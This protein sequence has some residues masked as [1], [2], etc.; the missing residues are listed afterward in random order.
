MDIEEVSSTDLVQL[1]E[2]A[3][4]AVIQSVDAPEEL[5]QEI[6]TDT[7]HHLET[8]LNSQS[9]VFLKKDSEDIKGFILI[10]DYWNLSDLFVIPK[11]HGTGIGKELFLVALEKCQIHTNKNYIRVNSSLNAQAFY[12]SVGFGEFTPERKVP[13]Y[14]V[15]FIYYF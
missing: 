1:K 12:K 4:I 5:K 8:G 10:Q 14:V 9:S 2:I 11:Y 7:Y 3:K 15:P 6:I 13:E